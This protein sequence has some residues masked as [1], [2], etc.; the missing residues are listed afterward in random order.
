MDVNFLVVDVPMAYN[1]IIGR[2][3]LS[4]LKAVVAPYLL[5]MQFELDNGGVGKLFGDQKMARE[6]Y[7]V[8]LKSL[9]RKEEASVAEL[10]RPSKSARKG[11]PEAVMT[12]LASAE[13]HGRSRPEPTVEIE[14][15]PLDDNRL[16]RVV[17]VGH[18]LAPTIKE[19]I[20]TL[21]R[22]YHDIFAFEPSEM[23]GITPE[24]MQH[25]LCLLYTSPS[26]RD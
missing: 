7:Y 9:G 1:V 5:L 14:E 2:P 21:L 10:P 22:Q 23:P 6:C 13:E 18:S 17:R 25:K 16:N 3:T 11:D 15:I 24:I 20:V 8:S 19:A 26:P 12:L 4:V